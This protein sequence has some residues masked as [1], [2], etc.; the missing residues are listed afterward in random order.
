MARG[1]SPSL[2]L[3]LHPSDGF[4][5]NKN[6]IESVSQ[7]VKMLILTAPGERIMYPNFGVGLRNYL[8]ENEM[9]ETYFEIEDKINEQLSIWMPFVELI[10]LTKRDDDVVSSAASIGLE[11]KYRIIPLNMFASVTLNISSQTN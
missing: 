6:Y 8:F 3:R 7:N 11:M 9:P 10:S 2:P 4:K 1:I 5:M